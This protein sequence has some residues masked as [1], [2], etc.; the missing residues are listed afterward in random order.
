MDDERRELGRLVEPA[1][2]SPLL[3]DVDVRG[4]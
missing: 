1:G 4:A 2:E 3:D